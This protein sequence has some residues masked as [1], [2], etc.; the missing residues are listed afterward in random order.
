[1]QMRRVKCTCTHDRWRCVQSMESCLLFLYW[2]FALVCSHIHRRSFVS[3][4]YATKPALPVL[5]T[6]TSRLKLGRYFKKNVIFNCT[7]TF[8]VCGSVVVEVVR[9]D[10]IVSRLL[11]KFVVGVTKQHLSSVKISKLKY[12]GCVF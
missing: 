3:R 2:T 5:I 4:R 8:L 6:V 9:M 10:Q 12:D 7:L 1:M 11:E